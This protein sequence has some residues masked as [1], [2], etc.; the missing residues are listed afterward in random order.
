MKQASMSRQ[1]HISQ[2][3]IVRRGRVTGIQENIN[4]I[5]LHATSSLFC[6]ELIAKLVSEHDQE[7]PQSQTADKPMAPRGRNRHTRKQTKQINQL[8]PH[9]DGYT[10]LMDTK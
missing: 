1:C 10:T 6:S 5:K 4:T 2:T 7:I 9:Q 3:N 8:S